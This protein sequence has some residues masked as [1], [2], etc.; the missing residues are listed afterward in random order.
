M[1][2]A[3]NTPSS[4]IRLVRQLRSAPAPSAHLASGIA[5]KDRSYPPAYTSLTSSNYLRLRPGS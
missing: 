3:T 1:S 5:A 4:S 2:E